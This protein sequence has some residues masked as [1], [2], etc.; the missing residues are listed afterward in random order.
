[1]TPPDASK[2]VPDQALSIPQA[3]YDHYN[4]H[5]DNVTYRA[6]V[7]ALTARLD[8]TYN[9]D[10]PAVA[11]LLIDSSLERSGAALYDGACAQLG[12]ALVKYQAPELFVL[13]E[14]HLHNFDPAAEESVLSAGLLDMLKML[15]TLAETAARTASAYHSWR[16]RVVCWWLDALASLAQAAHAILHEGYTGYAAE[17]LTTSVRYLHHGLGEGTAAGSVMDARLVRWLKRFP[18]P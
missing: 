10:Y 2:N 3:V 4:A 6:F 13:A 7:D 11:G 16:G 8:G 17:K 5:F 18:L 12:A 14:R 9:Y 15:Q 1:M